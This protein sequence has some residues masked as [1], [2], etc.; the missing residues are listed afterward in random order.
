[1][2]QFLKMPS[3]FICEKCGKEI[4]PHTVCQNCGYYKGR[5]VI[6]VLAELDKKERKRREKEITEKGKE[7][8]LSAEGLSK[9]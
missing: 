1:M 7:K 5:E 2:H 3:F 9:K 6:N 4:L 8:P